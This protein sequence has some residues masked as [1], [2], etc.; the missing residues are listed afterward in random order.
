MPDHEENGIVFI[1]IMSKLH[2]LDLDGRS[3]RLLLSLIETHSA[4]ATARHLGLTQSA[5]SHALE[6]LRAVL[7]DPLFVRAGRGLEPTD[8]ALSL[9]PIA[10][11]ALEALEHMGQEPAFDPATSTRRFVIAANDYQRDIVLPPVFRR[12]QREAPGIRLRIKTPGL[13]GGDMLRDRDCDLLISPYAPDYPDLIRSRL[14]EDGMACFYDPACRAAPTT[15]ADYLA[16]GHITIVYS[17]N[18]ETAIDQ[19]LAD[20]GLRRR[21]VLQLPNF[22]ALPVFLRGT[23][24]LVTTMALSQHFGL[25]GFGVCPPPLP[26]QTMPLHM[27]WHVRDTASPAHRWLREV[28]RD[29]VRGACPNA[30]PS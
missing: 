10:R 4:T 21:V 19:T 8:H 9:A 12:L 11:A 30:E 1:N 14:Y 7:G 3:L 2:Y 16:A 20:S 15:L 29:T 28:M 24:L 26:I 5:V 17:D 22:S 13:S 18:E 23:D 25:A 6:R 27:I